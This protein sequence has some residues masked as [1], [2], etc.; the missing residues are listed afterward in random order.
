MYRRKSQWIE[1][2][3]RASGDEEEEKKTGRAKAKTSEVQKLWKW[4]VDVWHW[5]SFKEEK[6]RAR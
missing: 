5:R 6:K 4:N 2:L 3:D 1:E